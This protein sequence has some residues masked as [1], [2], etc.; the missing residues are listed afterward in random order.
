MAIT[1]QSCYFAGNSNSAAFC[2]QCGATLSTS[3]PSPPNPT[4]PTVHAAPAATTASGTYNLCGTVTWL[5]QTLEQTDFDW[6]RFLSQLILFL[7]A[8]PLFIA[9]FAVTS[10]LWIVFM[11]LGFSSLSHDVSPFNM[12]N[13]VNSF[14][15]LVAII[16]PRVPKCYQ[17]AALRLTI[18]DSKCE[19]AAL[20]KGQL[21]S[22]TFRKGD[23]VQLSGV[24]KSG[25]LFVKSG[26]NKTLNTSIVLRKEYWN[27][28]FW[29]LIGVIFVVAFGLSRI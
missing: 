21:V 9:I 14:G 8:L 10:V 16:L 1:C 7:V 22:G 13:S 15:T 25:T 5:E 4:G 6:Y 23:D 24:W 3:Y 18:H 2:Q 26:F 17:V 19:N 28:V 20:I 11:V 29:I 12:L 27:V